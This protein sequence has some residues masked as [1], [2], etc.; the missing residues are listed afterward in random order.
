MWRRRSYGSN[1]VRFDY[2]YL[3]HPT[4]VTGAQ[5]RRPEGGSHHEKHVLY[6]V[7]ADLKV[8]IWVA[9]DPHGLQLLQLWTEIDMQASIQPRIEPVM[10]VLDRHMFLIDSIEFSQAISDTVLK[11]GNNSLKRHFIEHLLEIDIAKPDVCVV[12]DSRGHISAW[13]LDQIGAKAKS[14]HD[15]HNIAHLEDF[16]ALSSQPG[17]DECH[18]VQMLTFASDERPSQLCLLVHRH[19]GSI[20][21]WEG[22]ITEFFDPSPNP[23]RLQRAASWL[24][25]DRSIERVVP[26]PSRD[27]FLS[28]S[29][30]SEAAA[31]KLSSDGPGDSLIMQSQFE[32]KEAIIDVCLFDTLDAVIT[33]HSESL[34]LWTIRQKAGRILER[35][36]LE[37]GLHQ[38]SVFH[39]Q[40]S[41]PDALRHSHLFAVFTP[42]TTFSVWRVAK[43]AV[44]QDRAEAESVDTVSLQKCLDTKLDWSDDFADSL[45]PTPSTRKSIADTS[46]IVS[47]QQDEIILCLPAGHVYLYNIHSKDSNSLCTVSTSS[48]LD[49]N[50]S[51]HNPCL[52][53]LSTTKKLALVDGAGFHLTIW[54]ITTGNLECS[55]KYAS[56]LTNLRWL[57]TATGHSAL[58]VGLEHK[59]IVVAGVRLNPSDTEHTPWTEVREIEMKDQT[60]QAIKDFTWLG[61]QTLVVA[62]GIQ[63]LAVDSTLPLRLAF[64]NDTSSV[65]PGQGS[66]DLSDVIEILNCSLPIYHPQ[67]ILQ[68]ILSGKAEV[69]Q[70]V[71]RRLYKN[72]KFFSDGDSIPSDLGMSIKC[73]DSISCVSL[74]VVAKFF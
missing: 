50:T 57:T 26:S 63:L 60:S 30:N 43:S 58:A 4:T 5:W 25:H 53:A 44:W 12:L 68:I 15:A 17:L 59:I 65:M 38:R 69:A 14:R 13:A 8:R 31:W 67:H 51:V 16:N 42:P 23:A 72:L 74:F 47:V 37:K 27:S 35:Q 34:S 70:K 29:S 64:T 45:D 6:T 32:S 36:T 71:L 55:I 1:D 20:M 73:L 62:S 7:C 18:D 3:S 22:E 40:T 56:N 48:I 49:F 54:D 10:S 61:S 19:D 28:W 9:T 39:I 11:S 24:G 33:L 41:E 66:M 46:P 21:W 52:I 2:S